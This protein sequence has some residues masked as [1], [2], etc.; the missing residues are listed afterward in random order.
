MMG[1]SGFFLVLIGVLACNAQP[2][3]GLLLWQHRVDGDSILQ[4]PV[5]L[6]VVRHGAVWVADRDASRIVRFDSTG[7]ATLILEASSRGEHFLVPSVLQ[8]G[9]MDSVLLWDRGR[10]AAYLIVSSADSAWA[11]YLL[12][13]RSARNAF[14]RSL[15]KWR[16][17]I[18]LWEERFSDPTADTG[19]QGSPVIR[20]RRGGSVDTLM[21]LPPTEIVTLSDS[22]GTHV[23]GIMETAARPFALFMPAGE[24]LI[25]NTG[26]SI[27]SRVAS[28]G[29]EAGTVTI[30][31]A[32]GGVDSAARRRERES[33][34]ERARSL[35][36]QTVRLDSTVK[37]RML[38][39]V[40]KQIDSY[41]ASLRQ[42]FFASAYVGG[43]E[44][45]WLAVDEA[46]GSAAVRW[47]VFRASNGTCRGHVSIRHRG[48]IQAANVNGR[49][50]ATIEVMPNGAGLNIAVYNVWPLLPCGEPS[51]P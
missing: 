49:Y 25:G 3:S 6:A 38:A 37:E 9:G 17:G 41:V 46:D 28:E 39:Q 10:D 33:L 26:D 34:R 12:T 16:R 47:L 18:L 21:L 48:Y 30:Q 19:R 22:S 31:L 24:V 1:S 45:I 42:A 20:I 7:A 51:T 13:Y 2:Q 50:L 40:D 4:R 44:D 23:R 29:E 14:V 8:G 5:S 11:E 15:G 27:L 35:I 43:E 36:E 32:V